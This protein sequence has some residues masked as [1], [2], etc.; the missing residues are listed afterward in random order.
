MKRSKL[1]RYVIYCLVL[2]QAVIQLCFFII[3]MNFRSESSM[4]SSVL[5]GILTKVQVTND[6]QNFIWA[7][8]NNI[9]I[10]FIIFWISYWT[11]GVMGCI[12]CINLSFVLGT[13]MQL[14]IAMNSLSAISFVAF[15][16]LATLIITLTSFKFRI[17]KFDFTK[18]CEKESIVPEDISCKVWKQKHHK[19]IIMTF[20][21]ISIILLVAA[22]LETYVLKSIQ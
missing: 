8:S 5:L 12:C 10:L 3:G 13:I 7:F 14:A 22:V 9:S 17:D 6:F 19:K 16:F 4:M 11:F 18:M 21:C 20:L 2:I 15:E 1:R